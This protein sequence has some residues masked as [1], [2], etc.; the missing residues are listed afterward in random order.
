MTPSAYTEEQIDRYLSDISLPARFQRK[1]NPTKNIDYL[2][3][4]HTHQLSTI[5]YENLAIHYSKDHKVSLDPQKIYEKIMAGRG[6]GGYCMENTIFF[7]HVLRALG[8]QVYTAGARVRPRVN[9][10]PQG[11]YLGWVH[12]VNI[13]TLPSG[14]KYM[15]D[16][17][18]GGDGATAP[19]PLEEGIV[20]RS[21]GTQELRLIYD[22]IPQQSDKTRK[23]WIYQYR[24]GPDIAWNS[25]Y[26]FPEFEFT[27]ADLDVVNH[28]TSTSPACFQTFTVLVIKFLREEE[29]ICGKVML[30]DGDL[31]RNTGGKTEL[32]RRCETEDERVEVLRE[33]FRIELT[34]EEKVGIR[35]TIVELRG[36]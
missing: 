12:T 18:F 9:G 28:F 6:R 15:V 16:V 31:K 2:N 4:L 26:C 24:N 23:L 19:L 25:Y 36:N 5:P 21:V 11:D 33:W 20:T 13:V 32:V 8:F 27:L 34:Q 3:A 17:S 35:G 7:N 1:S 30:V 10:I 29:R 14:L 22:S